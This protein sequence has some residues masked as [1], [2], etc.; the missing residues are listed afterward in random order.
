MYVH[1]DTKI[2]V[3]YAL[4]ME[5][6]IPHWRNRKKFRVLTANVRHRWRCSREGSSRALPSSMAA[7]IWKEKRLRSQKKNLTPA[8]K[9][10][11]K[12]INNQNVSVI[13]GIFFKCIIQ[14]CFEKNIPITKPRSRTYGR[15]FFKCSQFLNGP[16]IA[17][18]N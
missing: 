15:V 10:E 11:G 12:P 17:R 2:W 1:L 13:C 8:G 5:V 9:R 6:P 3:Y 7:Q 14:Q 4:K 16:K 18:Y